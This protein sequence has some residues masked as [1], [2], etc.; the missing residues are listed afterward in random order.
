[1]N[2]KRQIS[3]KRNLVICQAFVREL[4]SKLD[5]IENDA[6][7]PIAEKLEEVKKIHAEMNKVGAE[8]DILNKEITL[9]ATYSVN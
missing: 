6:E 3:L 1:M 5:V 4:L 9:L 8:I 7:K 2:E